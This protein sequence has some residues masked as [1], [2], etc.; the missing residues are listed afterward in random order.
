MFNKCILIVF[1]LFSLLFQ[2]ATAGEIRLRVDAGPS[3]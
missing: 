3:M 2:P 1:R